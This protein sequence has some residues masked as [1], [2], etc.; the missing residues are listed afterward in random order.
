MNSKEETG[1]TMTSKVGRYVGTL[2]NAFVFDDQRDEHKP[3][4][5]SGSEEVLNHL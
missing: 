5:P 1:I 4:A 2:V 3:L